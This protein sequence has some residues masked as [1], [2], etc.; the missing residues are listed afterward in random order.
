MADYQP[1]N[2]KVNFLD[3]KNKLHTIKTHSYLVR[4]YEPLACF[5]RGTPKSWT[6][7][8]RKAPKACQ[9]CSK[10][11]VSVNEDLKQEKINVFVFG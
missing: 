6:D 2:G 5:Q 4:L 11:L 9:P 7:K 10:H 3:V 8:G 1:M